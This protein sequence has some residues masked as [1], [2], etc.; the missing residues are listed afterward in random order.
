LNEIRQIINKVN[1]G[2]GATLYLCPVH[3]RWGVNAKYCQ[4]KGCGFWFGVS[5]ADWAKAQIQATGEV[6]APWG[7]RHIGPRAPVSGMQTIAVP[8]SAPAPVTVAAMMQAPRPYNMVQSYEQQYVTQPVYVIQTTTQPHTYHTAPTAP[9]Y[10]YAQP[11]QIAPP[12]V[13]VPVTSLPH[14]QTWPGN[15]QT[16][17]PT[18]Y[19][20]V[21]CTSSTQPW[22]Q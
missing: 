7:F 14:Q 18:P 4:G 8:A 1:P 6:P 11:Q 15:S 13:Q 19:T 20:T 3:E 12:A 17:A 2:F 21:S 16:G 22:Y 9:T 10:S 5:G